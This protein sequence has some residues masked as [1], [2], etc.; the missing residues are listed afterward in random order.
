MTTKGKSFIDTQKFS[1]NID[2]WQTSKV[3]TFFALFY[4]AK[5][6]NHVLSSWTVQPGKLNGANVTWGAVP[7]TFGGAG[8]SNFT[9]CG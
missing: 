5:A 1:Q 6:F 9:T 3:T 7:T 2:S 8:C 4:N